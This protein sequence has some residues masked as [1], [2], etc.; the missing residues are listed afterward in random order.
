MRIVAGSAG[1]RTIFVPK[2]PDVRPTMDRVRAAIFSSLFQVVP[3]AHVLDLFSGTGALGIEALSRGAAEA[4]LVE[5][6]GRAIS[7]IERNLAATNVRAKVVESDVFSYLDRLAPRGHFEIVFADPPY[8][9]QEG[10][11]DFAP[12]LLAS[13]ALGDCLTANGIFV[14]EHLPGAKLPLGQRWE[15]FRQKRYGATEVAFL[16]RTGEASA[17]A[18]DQ[19]REPSGMEAK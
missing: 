18:P 16:R 6:D 2:G 12:E 14:L 7:T 9:K 1:G 15:C 11:R 5:K 4:V 19:V 10:E 13:A 3:G 17:G 8:A